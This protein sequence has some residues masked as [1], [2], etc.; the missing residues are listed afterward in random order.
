MDRLL[1]L[2]ISDKNKLSE[3]AS[4]NKGLTNFNMGGIKFEM[5]PLMR[6]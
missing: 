3:I 4:R 1:G 6:N 2:L 5:Q